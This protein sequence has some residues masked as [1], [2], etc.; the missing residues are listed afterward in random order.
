M[1]RLLSFSHS[2]INYSK[3]VLL[4][5]SVLSPWC[6]LYPLLWHMGT[7]LMCCGA[8]STDSRN[9]Q[10]VLMLFSWQHCRNHHG[11]TTETTLPFTVWIKSITVMSWSCCCCVIPLSPTPISATFLQQN[12]CYSLVACRYGKQECWNWIECVPDGHSYTV[13]N[14]VGSALISFK[15]LI[16]SE[17]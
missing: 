15:I 7:T 2:K 10:E 5:R 6:G 12:T 8:P 4:R 11:N 1:T 14:K 3:A 9:L 17:K 16:G 13:S